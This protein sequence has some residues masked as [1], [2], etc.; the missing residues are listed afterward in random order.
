MV[1]RWW[2][3]GATSASAT[4]TTTTATTTTVTT[5]T[6]TTTTPTA[7][8]LLPQ[9]QQ[10]RRWRCLLCV[11]LVLYNASA[12]GL[13]KPRATSQTSWGYTTRLLQIWGY[14]TKLCNAVTHPFLASNLLHKRIPAR[15]HAWP[16]VHVV[17]QRVLDSHLQDK[18]EAPPPL[19]PILAQGAE[20]QP[21]ICDGHCLFPGWHPTKKNTTPRKKGNVHHIADARLLLGALRQNWWSGGGASFFLSRSHLLFLRNP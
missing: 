13:V 14:T 6:T 10:Q 20:K 21:R 15:L 1:S 5:M 11:Q 2:V 17:S 16:A 18:E 8:A 4:T 3:V 7:T 19:Q 9:Y 12:S